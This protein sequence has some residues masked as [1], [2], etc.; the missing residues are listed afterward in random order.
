MKNVGSFIWNFL[1]W[2][3]AKKEISM[4]WSKTNESFLKMNIQS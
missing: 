2:N 4:L 3:F 1:I